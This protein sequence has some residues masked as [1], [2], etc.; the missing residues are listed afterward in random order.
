MRL[1]GSPRNAARSKEAAKMGTFLIAG[2]VFGVAG[3]L[4]YGIV[5]Q[6]AKKAKY[7]IL[8]G[9]EGASAEFV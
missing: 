2:V 5:G 9:M 7:G 6:S 1:R 3:G 8:C 4:V